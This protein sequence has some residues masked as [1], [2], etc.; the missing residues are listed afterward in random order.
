MVGF[1]S[2]LIKYAEFNRIKKELSTT[3]F[4]TRDSGLNY[5]FILKMDNIK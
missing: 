2:K 3:Q 5:C 4:T 1:C